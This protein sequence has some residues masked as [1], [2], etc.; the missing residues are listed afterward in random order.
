MDRALTVGQA[1]AQAGLVPIDAQVLLA[2][3]VAQPRAWLVAHRDDP[4]SRTHVDAFFALAKRRR[5]GA[6]VAHLTGV[7]EFWGLPLTVTPDVLIPRPETETLV[8]A[9]LGKLA[10]NRNRARAGSWHGL[11]RHRAG[12][13]ARAAT[14]ASD[15]RSIAA[16]RR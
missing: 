10:P 9:A 4:L 6:P 8:E 1:L 2:H 12:A 7:R 11:G 3:V 5:D 14:R 16:P 15:W 13:R